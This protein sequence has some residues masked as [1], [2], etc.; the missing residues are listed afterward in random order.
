MGHNL[1][2]TSVVRNNE[3]SFVGTSVRSV[4]D[5]H[6][7]HSRLRDRLDFISHANH[8]KYIEEV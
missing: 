5:T 4:R 3:V 7:R 2:L 1:T 8:A 6:F